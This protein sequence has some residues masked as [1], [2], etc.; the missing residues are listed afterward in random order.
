[1]VE[2]KGREHA[3]LFGKAFQVKFTDEKYPMPKASKLYVIP[4]RGVRKRKR[5]WR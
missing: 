2:V 3:M 4:E 1:M 5:V